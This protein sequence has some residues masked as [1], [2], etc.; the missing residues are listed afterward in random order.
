MFTLYNL[1]NI[2]FFNCMLSIYV[3]ESGIA[4]K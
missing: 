2:N 1:Q 3:Q 4:N